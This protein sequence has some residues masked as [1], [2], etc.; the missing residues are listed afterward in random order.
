M[1]EWKQQ[2]AKRRDARHGGDAPKTK[3]PGKKDRKRWCRGKKGIE[4]KPQARRYNDVKGA[5]SWSRDWWVLVCTEC[6]KELAQYWP[7][8]FAIVGGGRTK[9]DPPPDWVPSDT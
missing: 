6:G 4:H 5:S 8:T 7:M 2:S 1:S 3:A 9:A